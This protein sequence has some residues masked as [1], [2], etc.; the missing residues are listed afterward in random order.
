MKI[1]SDLKG[2][3]FDLDGTLLD[4]HMNKFYRSYNRTLYKVFPTTMDFGQFIKHQTASAQKSINN[5][6]GKT[7]LDVFL[8]EF[9]P[10]FN[11]TREEGEAILRNYYQNKYQTLK[12]FTNPL[13]KAREVVKLVI[14]KNFKVSIATTPIFMRE[15]IEARMNWAEID[16]LPFD[17]ITYAE[18][19]TTCKPNLDYY[20]EVCS[21]L[22]LKP[23]EC[24]VVGDEH[25]DMVAK[26]LGF[27]TF[28][29]KS[30]M[31]RLK[32]DTPKPDFVGNLQDLIKLL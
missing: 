28:L 21:K 8:E 5:N 2:I 29:I 26:S 24:L 7:N 18:D 16:D 31:T 19:F 9:L 25:N 23:E 22:E 10:R 4:I 15:A 14:E 13:P 20:R 32:D 3:L 17:L 30:Q 27:Q 12:K 1:K 6:T 11:L